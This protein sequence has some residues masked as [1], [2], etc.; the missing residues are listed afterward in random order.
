MPVAPI[1]PSEALTIFDKAIPEQVF[2]A[3]NELIRE[4]LSR[5]KTQVS[6]TFKE[7]AVVSRIVDKGISKAEVYERGWLDVEGHYRK[8]GWSVEYDKPGFNEHYE[9]NFKF[10]ADYP[11]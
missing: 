1:S 7:S 5:G 6:T 8:M 11:W 9:A 2:V 4:N 3:F 10:T